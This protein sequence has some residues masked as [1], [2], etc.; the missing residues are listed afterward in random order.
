M[1]FLL[2]FFVVVVVVVSSYDPDGNTRALI[3]FMNCH[4]VDI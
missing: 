4:F 2:L 1:I 3:T